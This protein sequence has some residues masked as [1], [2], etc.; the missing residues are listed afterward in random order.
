METCHTVYYLTSLQPH[1]WRSVRDTK[2]SLGRYQ[3]VVDESIVTEEEEEVIVEPTKS[4]LDAK[5]LI[6]INH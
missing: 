6:G 1:N 5:H 2:F 3:K 4:A